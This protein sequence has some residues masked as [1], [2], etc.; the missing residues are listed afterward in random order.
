L[1]GRELV[2]QKILIGKVV[3]HNNDVSI[4]AEL[5]DARDGRHVWGER[6]DRKISDLQFLQSELAQDIA[7]HFRLPLSG[8]DQYT[9]RDVEAYQLYLKGRYF[10]NKR[11][12]ESMKK[13]LEFFEQAVRIDP[14][15]TLAYAG[16]ADCYNVLSQVGE[17]SP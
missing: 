16:L 3:Q 7:V 11:T 13:G 14:N 1:I 5:V 17:F 9:T 15:Y 2:V 4:S 10:W 6:Y 12:R 8:K